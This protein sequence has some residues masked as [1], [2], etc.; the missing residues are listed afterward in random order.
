[1]GLVYAFNELLSCVVTGA[2]TGL[3][4]LF[5]A[6]MGWF[7]TLVLM[8]TEEEYKKQLKEEEDD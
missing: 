1:M 2:A 6:K 4:V 5:F 8:V 3:T 7:P